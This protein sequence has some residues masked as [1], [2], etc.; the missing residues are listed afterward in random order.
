MDEKKQIFMKF[1]TKAIHIGQKPNLKEGGTGDLM[2]PIHLSSTYAQK[3]V[4]KPIQG[5]AYSRTKN[6]TR[7]A[8]QECLASL[9]N[10]KYGLAY[11]SGL[12]AATN[13]LYLLKQGDHL[14]AFDDLYGGTKRL[15]NQVMTNYGLSFSY[16]DAR[17]TKN[18]EQA[19]RPNTKMIWVES[20]TNPL[21]KLCDIKAISEVA[22][23]RNILLVVD[24][25]FMTPYYQRPLELGADIVL[26]STTKYLNGHS[27]LIGGALMLNDDELFA[28]LEFYQNAAG[29]V[30][31]PF[32]CWLVLRGL[33]TLAVRMEKHNENAQKVAEFLENHPKIAKVYYPGLKSHPQHEL[34]KRQAS[35]FGGTFS[36]EIKGDINS[37]KKFLESLEIFTLAESLGGVK[38]LI[39]CPA[40]M[41]HDSVPKEEREAI[42]IKD[43]LIRVSVGIEDVEDLIRD[44]KRGLK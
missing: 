36:F 32:D 19:V 7:D 22:K 20:P 25:T 16:V 1:A 29:A 14:I 18:V 8:L 12:A 28:K 5:R 44:L 24:N 26:H 2:P 39:E 33:K 17:K 30:P 27:D 3:E 4:G 10:A 42:G 41:T 35:G 40:L 37:A 9:E 21:I 31:S 11:A 6:P 13:V 43:T 38:S 15:F 23:K 34:A